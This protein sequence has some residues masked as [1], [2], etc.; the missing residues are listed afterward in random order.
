M[1]RSADVLAEARRMPDL[2]GRVEVRPDWSVVVGRVRE[3]TAAWDDSAAVKRLESAGCRVVHGVGTVTGPG[4]VKVDG[5]TYEARRAIVLNPGTSPVVPPVEGLAD[6]PYWT[7]REAI[8]AKSL[9]SPLIVLGGGAVG[10]ELAQVFARFGSRV[11]VVEAGPCLLAVEE[12][13]AGRLL[14]DVF[15]HDGIRVCSNAKAE[16]VTHDG[17]GFAVA[18]SSGD[19]LSADALLVATGR[20]A[21][22]RDLGLESV[23]VD[24]SGR[25]LEVDDHL[26][27]TDGMWAIGD[28]TGK[29]AFTHVSMYQGAIAARDILGEEGPGADYRA[30]PRVTF[31]DPEVGAVGMTEKQALEAGLNVR[32]GC[33]DLPS[34]SRG[35]VHADGNDGFIKVVADADR[36][37]LVGA[38]SAGPYGG[39]ILGALAVAVRAEVS[40]ATL[41][42]SMWAY[43]TF[44]RAI[45]SALAA[46]DS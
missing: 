33:T 28:A 38:T 16:S 2:A 42:H 4:R 12:P 13:E 27:L 36:G 22:L 32:T 5:Q 19:T 37:V 46:L 39:E 8:E 41:R 44:H 15:G 43:P 9:P 35:Y 29:G 10:V 21:R 6:V 25:F 45:E 24:P 18:L 30:L 3:V 7:S 17:S 26:R 11:T 31:T 14:S 34:S 20:G 40:V 23:G 1:I